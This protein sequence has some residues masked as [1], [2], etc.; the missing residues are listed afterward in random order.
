MTRAIP[1]L[2]GVIEEVVTRRADLTFAKGVLFTSGK[3][4]EVSAAPVGSM[5]LCA[6]CDAYLAPTSYDY[7]KRQ[8]NAVRMEKT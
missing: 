1:Y 5:G 7:L 8:S 3:I 4:W 2:G 6:R